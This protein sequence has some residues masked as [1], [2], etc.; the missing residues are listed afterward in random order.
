MNTMKTPGFTADVSLYLTNGRYSVIRASEQTSESIFP[1]YMAFE[2]I[3]LWS[4]FGHCLGTC[5]LD[6]SGQ[7]SY[8]CLINCIEN[9]GGRPQIPSVSVTDL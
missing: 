7:V 8:Y 6:Y 4:C 2:A 1:A 3:A 5:P 9:C